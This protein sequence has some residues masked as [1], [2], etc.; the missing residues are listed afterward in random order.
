MKQQLYRIVWINT[1]T[2][3][4]GEGESVL[5]IKDAEAW[6]DK[7]NGEFP[8]IRHWIEPA[9]EEEDNK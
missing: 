9:K 8:K 6:V 2:G 3:Q 5:S 4:Q 7:L 1:K